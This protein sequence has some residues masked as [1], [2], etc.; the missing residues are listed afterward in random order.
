MRIKRENKGF[1][2]IELIVVIAIFSIIGVAVGGFLLT[3]SRSYAVSANELDIQEEAQL[4]ANQVQEMIMDTSY[5]IAYQFV[6]LDDEG[7]NLIKYMENDAAV[8]PEG[9][10][11]SQKDLYIYGKDHYYHIFWNKDT[12][13]MYL[14]EFEKN[15]DDDYVLV[16]GMPASGVLFGE[17]IS[18][19]QVDLSK[20]ASDRMVSFNITFKK[21]GSDRDY[22]VARTISL[23]NNVMTNKPAEDIYEAAGEEFQPAADDMD[24]SPDNYSMWPEETLHYNVLVKCTN[25]GVPSQQVNWTLN[26]LSGEELDADTKISASNILK[27]GKNEKNSQIQAIATV[28]GYDYSTN[29]PK[30]LNKTCLVNVRQIKSLAIVSNAFESNP[31]SPGGTYEIKV[32]MDGQ[33][34]PDNLADTGGIYPTFLQG[35]SYAT[36]EQTATDGLI[37]TYTVT[38]K[39]DAPNQGPIQLAFKPSRTQYSSVSVETPLY[40]IADSKAVI[41]DIKAANNQKEWLRLGSVR[42]ELTFKSN[43]VKKNYFPSNKLADGCSIRYTYKVYDATNNLVQTSYRTEGSSSTEVKTD[44]FKSM[45]IDDNYALASNATLSDKVFLQSGYVTVSAELLRNVGGST[46]VLGLSDEVTY[47]IPRAKLAVKRAIEDEARDN[48]NVYITKNQNMASVYVSFSEG[49]ASDEYAIMWDYAQCTPNK[50][51]DKDEALSDMNTRKFVVKGAEKADYS[52]SAKN[53]IEFSYGGLPEKVNIILTSP[54]IKNQSYYVPT[55]TSEWT[56]TE[57]S[58]WVYYIDDTHKME[59]KQSGFIWKTYKGTFYEKTGGNWKQKK[60]YTMSSS[61]KSW[62]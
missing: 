61:D 9:S 20:V 28:A 19:F 45:D 52:A 18:N 5:G 55:E 53:K 14:E 38:I 47:E 35:G 39:S 16:E 17:Y 11:I 56:K 34:L 30:P 40:N 41:F 43:D 57:T 51:G 23:R 7:N 44:Y 50:L 36:I 8:L 31:I 46:V 62:K 29:T 54:N 6:G 13:Q 1:S 25:G 12:S 3:A 22:M 21:N 32:K 42:T 49:F 2:L 10:T 4:V 27:V 60:E 15:A 37:A 48:M 59:I 58:K 26:P 24:V 33:Y